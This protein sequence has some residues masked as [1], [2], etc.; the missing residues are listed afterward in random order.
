MNDPLQV[1]FALTFPILVGA[2]LVV[3]IVLWRSTGLRAPDVLAAPTPSGG[4][5]I[6]D[7]RIVTIW[8]LLSAVTLLVAFAIG[9]AIVH[10]VLFAFGTGVASLA[11]AG[12]IVLLVVVPVGW[13]LVIRRHLRGDHG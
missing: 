11:L 8:L 6:G 9:F 12:G 5:L 4:R 13:A 2:V 7:L 3:A 10:A 1:V